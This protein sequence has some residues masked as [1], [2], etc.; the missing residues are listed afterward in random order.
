MPNKPSYEEL[1]GKL[2]KMEALESERRHDDIM[3]QRLFNLSIDMLC[4][5]DIVD[6]Y[7]RYMNSAFEKTLGYSREELLKE[8]FINLVHP[9]DVSLTLSAVENLNKGEPVT[10][11][12]NRYRCKDGSYKWLAWTS[13]PVPDQGLTYAVARD[14]TERKKAEDELTRH[15]DHLQEIVKEHTQDLIKTNEELHAEIIERKRAEKAI[16]QA[17]EEWEKTFDAVPDLIAILDKN[18]RIVR[19]NKAMADRLGLSPGD[20]VGLTCYEHVHGTK[21]PP[22]FC[23]HSKLLEDGQRHVTEVQEER[24]GGYFLVSVSPLHDTGGR[25]IGSVHTAHDIIERKRAEEALQ[26]SEE[27]YRRLANL[28]PQVVFETDKKGNLNFANRLAFDIFG[29]TEDN[30]KKGLNALQMII[31]EDRDKAWQRMQRIMGGAKLV[32]AEYTALRKDGTTYPAMI[33][34]T[35]VMSEGKPIGIRGIMADLSEVKRAH[36][37]LRESEEKIARL[38]KMEALGLLAGGVA[39][40]L[41]NVLS[42]IVSYPELILMD[43][44]DDSKLR[45][46]IKTMQESGHRATA[47]VQDLLTIARGVATTRGPLNINSIVR[48]YISSPELEKLKQYHPTVEIK[49]SLDPHLLNIN[50]SHVHIRKVIMNLVSNASE[51]IENSGNVAISTMN[52]YVDRPLRGYND[53][54]IGEYAVLCISDSGSGIPSDDLDR[55]FDPFYTKKVMGRSGTGL[56]LSVVWNVV[57]DH[58]GYINV[59]TGENGTAFE[60]YFPTTKEKVPDKALGVP[61]KDLKGNGETIL[62]VDD[63]E[64]QREISCNMLDTLGYKTSAVSSGEEAFEYLKEHTVDLILL[65]MIMDPGINGRET[66]DRIIKIHPNQKAIIVSGFAETDEVKE[67]Q[68]LGAGQYIKKPLTLETIGLAVK[69]ELEE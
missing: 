53:V 62:V 18:H 17:K 8:P 30:F 37:A 7:F 60:L 24:L 41:N 59:T 44:P 22:S 33:Y 45:K 67:T 25:L 38:K 56:G 12:D 28:L 40:D 5:G 31:P 49:D 46:P 14:I 51:A 54:K 15:R 66:Y 2:K 9:D 42:G 16:S 69:E 36:E 20:A 34:S 43:L 64:S 47:I 10:N 23:P 58:E 19:V 65:D 48:D 57:Q 29:Y 32:G 39:H 55:I 21:E 61:I 35:P 11:F 3:L 13:M 4:V 68:K 1:G 27:K 63:V 50:G 52:R 26:Q 6:G